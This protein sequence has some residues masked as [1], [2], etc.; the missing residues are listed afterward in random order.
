MSSAEGVLAQAQDQRAGLQQAH[1]DARAA[2]QEAEAARRQLDDLE[3]RIAAAGQEVERLEGE[4][5]QHRGRLREL[6]GALA[7]E[8]EIERSFAA[9]GQAVADNESLNAKLAELVSLGER[10]GEQQRLVDAARHELQVE[11]YAAAE[12]VQQLQRATQAL[13]QEPELHE[14]QARLNRLLEREAEREQTAA[15]AQDLATEIAALEAENKRAERDAEQIK[16]KIDLLDT[17]DGA[18][19]GEEAQAHC[20]L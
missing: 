15:Q 18:V 5:D 4:I 19:P 14:V 13:E 7:E 6:E 2:L 11:R 17:R 10:R 20:P 1:D 3:R 8:A 12:Q 16:E 9:Y